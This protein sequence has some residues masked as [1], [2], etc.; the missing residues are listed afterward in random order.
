MVAP[1]Q[2]RLC[3]DCRLARPQCLCAQ[4]APLAHQTPIYVLQ[5]PA[6][7]GHAKNTLRLARLCLPALRVV[8]GE[9]E[10]D[11]EP[12]RQQLSGA[13]AV[14][15][16]PG[17]GSAPLEQQAAPGALLFLDATW[18]KAAKMLALNPWLA[19]LPRC[20][21]AQAPAG[22]YRLR[23]TRVA[24]G[25]ST[26][27]AIAYSLTVL[28]GL[29]VTPLYRLQAAWVAARMRHMPAEVKRRYEP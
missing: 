4:A 21:F 23:K 13:G 1:S 27:E 16:W 5:H 15:C 8:V 2:G 26:L 28:E 11:F 3:P 19:A 25:L 10:A 9:C 18:R 29:D 7:A 22:D 6:E 20:S 24:G 17:A 12:V 14:L